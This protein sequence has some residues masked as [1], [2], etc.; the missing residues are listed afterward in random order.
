MDEECVDDEKFLVRLTPVLTQ[1]DKHVAQRPKE[2]HDF[3]Q[4][5]SLAAVAATEPCFNVH[6]VCRFNGC[7]TT[8]KDEQFAP[9]YINL[10]ELRLWDCMTLAKLVKRC[11]WNAHNFG[12]WRIAS[13][14]RTAD[15]PGLLP[16]VLL[17]GLRAEGYFVDVK[18]AVRL[19]RPVQH[20]CVLSFATS[21]GLKDIEACIGQ[22]ISHRARPRGVGATDVDDGIDLPA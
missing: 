14:E 19:L 18:A 1:L 5:R 10:D 6:R 20:P 4:Q 3:R 15:Y 11:N 17:A 2:V 13:E 22:N 21:E 12:S 16:K 7:A 8:I 9:L